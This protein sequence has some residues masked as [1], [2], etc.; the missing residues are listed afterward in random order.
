MKSLTKLSQHAHWLLRAAIAGVFIYHGLDKF[1]KL[2]GMA[3]MMNMPV[4]MLFMVAS[5]ETVGGAL[6]LLGGFSKDWIT[7]LGALMLVPVMLGAIFMVHW[8]QWSFVASE[9]HA[10]GGMEFQVTLLLASLYLFVKGNNV[11]SSDPV[12]VSN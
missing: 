11:S 3:A 1:P 12:P 10:M 9:T 2:D 8:G 5:A 4:A 6:V 7:R